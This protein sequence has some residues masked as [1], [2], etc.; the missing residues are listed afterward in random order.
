MVSS[1]AGV[2]FR[3]SMESWIFP[4]GPRPGQLAPDASLPDFREAS[5]ARSGWERAS[6]LGSRSQRSQTSCPDRPAPPRSTPSAISWAWRWRRFSTCNCCQWNPSC[7]YPVR[8]TIPRTIS[9]IAPLLA[10]ESGPRTSPATTTKLVVA[11][12]SQATRASRSARRNA[13][14][15]ASEIRSQILSGCPS[16]TDSDENRWLVGDNGYSLAL[17]VEALAPLT[18]ATWAVCGSLSTCVA[19]GDA[20]DETRC[21]N[22]PSRSCA[23]APPS[24][25]VGVSVVS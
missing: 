4:S 16:D 7:S 11:K 9:S 12:H 22:Q 23:S 5:N 1:R 21:G 3:Y 10:T 14:R 8:C 25:G 17:N 18:S 19:S 2:P 20:D 15:T 6:V 13:S 24:V